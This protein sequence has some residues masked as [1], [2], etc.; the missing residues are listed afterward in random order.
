MTMTER[1][2]PWPAGTPCWVD[3][4]TT[5]L[6]S[7]ENFYGPLFGWQL[8]VGAPET[9]GY[10]LADIGGRAVAGLGAMQGGMEHPPVWTT[11]L[12]TDDAAA[13]AAQIAAAG[14]QVVMPPMDVMD[15]GVMA[16][17]QDPTGGT[18]G[19]W[20]SKQH[21]GVGLANE[22]G[23]LTWNE[24]M[25]RDY[26]AAKDFYAAVF[27]YAYTEMGA[28]GFEYSAIEVDGNTVGGLGVLPADVPAQVPAHWR[29]YFA[30]DDAD[31]TVEA[32]T[33]AGGSVLRPPADMPYGRHADV[34]DAQGAMFSIIKP[35]SP[36]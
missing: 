4:M 18:F 10:V 32:V 30:V 1:D 33:Q 21:T 19:I 26:A 6:D 9:G 34:A 29:V 20:Q 31:A 14:G 24:L 27:G 15:L 3:L 8:S 12:A 11:Y 2:T 22:S 13:T 23:A 28:D 25:T 16:V 7:A 17:A 5:D 35:A 36:A